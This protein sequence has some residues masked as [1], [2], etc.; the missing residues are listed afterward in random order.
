MLYY[1]KKRDTFDFTMEILLEEATGRKIPHID[2]ISGRP[3]CMRCQ[4]DVKWWFETAVTVPS[5]VENMNQFIFGGKDIIKCIDV[6]QMD[7]EVC[8][9]VL[10][11]GCAVGPVRN[12]IAIPHLQDQFYM[13]CQ[14]FL[15]MKYDQTGQ[16][17][18][19]DPLGTPLYYDA[20]QNA[21]K[22]L[23]WGDYIIWLPSKLVYRMCDG[24]DWNAVLA[25]GLD[26]HKSCKEKSDS[27]G[28]F[29]FY[30]NY[31]SCSSSRTS[32]HMAINHY[33][34][35]MTEIANL[36]DFLDKD[37]LFQRKI[38]E[39]FFRVSEVKYTENVQLLQTID[40]NIW[41]MYYGKYG[42]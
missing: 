3:F 14:H 30:A 12:G 40:N 17:A 38:R 34:R 1:G 18:V 15:F 37:T 10:A 24:I 21:E 28:K 23:Q 7:G 36:L 22:V 19:T 4:N 26:R 32:L 33:L 35:Q 39:F 16:V 41:E 9:R 8:R 20:E 42:V 31:K 29:N 2:C 6:M 25:C 5:A 27:I 13:G 11:D